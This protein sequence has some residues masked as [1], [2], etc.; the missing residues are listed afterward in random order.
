MT[1]KNEIRAFIAVELT[2]DVQDIL[3][4]VQAQLKKSGADIKWVRPKNIHLTLK[5]LGNIPSENITRIYDAMRDTVKE[6]HPFSITLTHIGAFPKIERPKVVWIGAEENQSDIRQIS[7]SLEE[8]LASLNFKKEE[9][10]F[11]AHITIGR[12]R[13]SLN[14][15]HLIKALKT[16]R[17]EHAIIQHV[18]HI[19]LFKSTL[20]PKGPIYEILEQADFAK[21]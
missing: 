3:A 2:P 21:N 20:T 6:Q 5:F 10:D 13:S 18:D 8:R 4:V 19:T 14:R 17:L 9:R 12:V 1:E 16:F 11:K 15:H 7:T